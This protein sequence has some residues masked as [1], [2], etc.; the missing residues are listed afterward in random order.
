MA[1]ESVVE[2]T[3][4]LKKKFKGFPMFFTIEKFKNS[5]YGR[6]KA[7]DESSLASLSSSLSSSSS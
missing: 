6:Y 2:G 5:L 4:Q 3:V 1:R 7:V